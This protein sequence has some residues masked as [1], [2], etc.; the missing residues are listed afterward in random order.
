MRKE[1]FWHE[2]LTEES[3]KKLQEL[4]KEIQVIVIGGWAVWLWT[5]Q[6]KSKDIDIIVDFE[7][8]AKLKEKYYLEKNDRLKKYEVKLEG[9]DIDVYVPFYSKLAIPIE[10]L[11]KEKVLIEGIKTVSCEAL[12]ILKQGAEIERQ[13]TT[14]GQ[15]DLIDLLTLLIYAPINFKKYFQ[16][17]KTFKKEEFGKELTDTIRKF[18]VNDSEKYL[19][20]NYRDFLKKK[21][22]LLEQIKKSRLSQ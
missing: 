13:N 4:A 1:E 12:L 19:G 16:L 8:L 18:N 15:K 9:F 3:W 14:K 21:K 17:L 11:L 2:S 7:E 10:Y 5:K 22:Q 20:I 6:H